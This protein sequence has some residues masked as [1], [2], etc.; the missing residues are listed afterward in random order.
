MVEMQELARKNG[1]TDMTD[2]KLG[3]LLGAFANFY[4]SVP[5]SFAVNKIADW[6]PEV[7]AEQVGRVL[8]KSNKSIFWHHFCVIEESVA[9]PELA[10]EHLVA[11]DYA[12][13]EQFIAARIAA[14]YYDCDEETILNADE[15]RLDI[16]EVK[17]IMDFG[18][19]ELGLNDAWAR[20]LIDDCIFNQPKALCEGKSWVME[21]LQQ[22]K[23]GKIHFR[24]IEQIKRFRE[25]GNK[26]YLVTPNPILRGWKPTEIESPP[27]LL[28]DIP[29]KDEDIPDGRPE[30]DKFFAQYGGREKMAQMLMQRLGEIREPAKKRKIGRNELCPCGSGKKYKKC[31]GR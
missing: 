12:D 4:W 9:E 3:S 22:E 21:V 28:D 19:T 17:A 18:Q 23:L 7:T 31:C 24:T 8:T 13:Y 6:H 1:E 16:P 15:L 10:V 2:E 29:E 5:V 11:I 20:Q 27:V 26:L 14:P 25:L 30:M